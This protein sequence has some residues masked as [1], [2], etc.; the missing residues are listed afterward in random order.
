MIYLFKRMQE[1]ST[2]AGIAAFLAS[3]G[4]FGLNETDWNLVLG[5]GAAVSAALSMLMKDNKLPDDVAPT[6]IS[7]AIKP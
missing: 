4:L 3:L 7:P 1:P 6:D 5:A 2:Y